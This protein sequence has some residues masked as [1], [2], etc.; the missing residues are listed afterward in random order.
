VT[1]ASNLPAGNAADGGRSSQSTDSQTRER[2]NYEVGETRREIVRAAGGVR[3]VTVAVLVDGQS[4]AQADGTVVLQ[5]RPEE[6][7]SALR[8]LVSAAV[9]LD[10]TRGD[11]V[12]VRTLAFEPVPEAGAEAGAS[13]FDGLT[14]DMMTLIQLG[15]LAIVSLVLGLFV[16]RPILASRTH[17]RPIAALAGPSPDSILTGEIDDGTYLA[18]SP[19]D[20]RM[21]RTIGE[22]REPPDPAADPADRLRRLIAERQEDTVTILKRWIDS[23]ATEKV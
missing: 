5:P 16:V 23:P 12:T 20:V 19:P 11:V 10:E 4:A 18:A 9:G 14:L 22:D 7:L 3:R 6:E 15:V 2:I 13:V 21:P 17:G 1:V 8:D